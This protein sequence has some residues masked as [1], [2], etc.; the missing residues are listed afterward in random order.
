M[1]PKI[2]R[3]HITYVNRRM[4]NW[5]WLEGQSRGCPFLFYLWFLPFRG[6]SLALRADVWPQNV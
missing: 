4:G 1:C 3:Y 2:P 5:V 6:L